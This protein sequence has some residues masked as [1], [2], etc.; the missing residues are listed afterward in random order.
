M[1][2]IPCLNSESP[3]LTESDSSRNDS[4]DIGPDEIDALAATSPE[5]LDAILNAATGGG[6]FS[7]FN[8][9]LTAQLGIIPPISHLTDGAQGD[10]DMPGLTRT[11]TETRAA[12]S[13]ERKRVASRS[14]GAE[15][16]TKRQGISPIV[17]ERELLPDQLDNEMQDD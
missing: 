17:E 5:A 13:P 6:S 1:L 16:P 14:T 12:T 4:L 3:G 9:D 11:P 7:G 15:S 10:Q 8:A 2:T